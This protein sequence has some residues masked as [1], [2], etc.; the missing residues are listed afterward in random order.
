MFPFTSAR[1]RMSV[2]VNKPNSADQKT[3][4]TASSDSKKSNKNND[5]L[6]SNSNSA[7]NWTLY[8][9]GASELVLANCSYYLDIDGSE[10]PLTPK[11]RKEFE[12][13]IKK[14]SS[15]AL[16]CIALAHRNNISSIVDP[17]TCTVEECESKLEKDLCL[18]AIAGIMDPLRPDVIS[19]VAICQRAGIFVRMVTGDNLDTAEAIARQAGILTDGGISIIGEEFRKLTP[20]QLDEILPRL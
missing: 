14:F 17:N 4:Q 12:R 2:L 13:M 1:K 16:R 8:H 18:D 15:E 6:A 3:Q 11:K 10:K 7:P 5:S 9:K 19:A 20:A